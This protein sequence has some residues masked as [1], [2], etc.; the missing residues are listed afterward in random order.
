MP[1]LRR[2]RKKLQKQV[3]RWTIWLGITLIFII[4]MFSGFSWVERQ[5]RGL[6]L[7][8]AIARV[9]GEEIPRQQYE[10]ALIRL[11]TVRFP[12]IEPTGLGVL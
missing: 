7:P 4:G 10:Q 11:H 6:N 2:T 3:I 5:V 12:P 8:K 9:N 1:S